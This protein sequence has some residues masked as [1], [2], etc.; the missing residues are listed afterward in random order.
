[1]K[2]IKKITKNKMKKCIENFFLFIK[3]LRTD[4]ASPDLLK[5]LNIEYYGKKISLTNIS[6]ITVEDSKTLRINTFD[7]NINKDVEKSIINSNLGLNPISVGD[8]IRV[9]IPQLTEERRKDL[10]KI[11]Y[12]KSEKCKICIRMVRKDSNNIIK[13]FKKDE[14]IGKHDEKMYKNEVQ[15]LTN[16]YIK[17]VDRL[18]NVKE[19]SLLNF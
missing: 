6:S 2:N 15:N 10:I 19:K 13:N 7:K 17:E 8:I 4:R 18:K 16:F 11:L 9:P 1:M 12:K 3:K 14:N 5:D